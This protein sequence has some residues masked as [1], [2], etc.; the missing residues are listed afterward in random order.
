MEALI[1]RVYY[2]FLV[3]PNLRLKKPRWFARPSAMTVFALSL[4]LY[5][6]ISGGI[7]Y[8]VI[9]EPPSV[10][11]TV[12]ERGNTIPVA[13]MQYRVNSQYIMEGLA[14]GFMFVFGG[15][16]FVILDQTTSPTMPKLN[17][18][19]LLGLGFTCV[20]VAFFACRVFF[21]MKM[22]GYLMT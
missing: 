7:I 1:D 11:S 3:C 10:G 12:D 14:A 16:G 2:S 8:D 18:T 15:I 21:R 9:V 13:F 20:L 22:P 6:L 5:F 4:V 17:R 19:L